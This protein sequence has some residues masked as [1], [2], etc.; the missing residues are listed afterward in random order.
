MIG[1]DDLATA[2]VGE[3]IN[4]FS[5]EDGEYTT[6]QDLVIHLKTRK[7]TMQVRDLLPQLSQNGVVIDEPM[8]RYLSKKACSSSSL[9]EALK[10][11]LHYF[12]RTEEHLPREEKK[13]FDIGTFCHLAFLEPEKFDELVV[14]PN[15][16]LASKE[17]VNQMVTF[18]EDLARKITKSTKGKKRPLRRAQY[19]ARKTGL[20]L[21]KMDGLREYLSQLKKYCGKIAV[22]ARTFAIVSYV[23]RHYNVYGGGIIPEL[24]KGAC[25][26]TSFHSYD[27]E[28]GLPVKIRPDAFNLE[29]NLGCNA[30]ISVK[31]T[32]AETIEKFQYDAA[33]YLYHLSEGM[34]LE[35]ASQITG[36]KFTAVI[37][38]MIQTVAP[39]LPAVFLYSPDDLAN[40]KYRYRT[41]LRNVREAMDKKHWPG[42]DSYAEADDHGIIAMNLPEWSRRE[43]LPQTIDV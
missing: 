18:Y 6:I 36:R 10:T 1:F 31:T 4:P 42:F 16:S 2:S 13:H 34:Y 9:K 24:L 21:G 43:K 3:E 8:E 39:F 22:D 28:T 29:E 19:W 14:E 15:Y 26:E 23:K 30:I 12:V 20:D 17:G 40:G 27:E 35:V 32:H 41:A 37:C 5:Y 33:K 7:K 25:F 11:P 38:I